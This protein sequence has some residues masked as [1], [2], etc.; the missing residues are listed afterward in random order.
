MVAPL[1]AAALIGG[2]ATI[3][4]GAMSNRSARKQA[5]QQASL[6]RE[7]AQNSIQWKTA[8]AKAAGVHPLY[9]LGTAST[10]YSPITYADSMGPALASAGQSVARGYAAHQSQKNTDRQY[11]KSVSDSN[12]MRKMAQD[13]M[14][15]QQQQLKAEINRTN[16]DTALR[17]MEISAHARAN[18]FANSQQDLAPTTAETGDALIVPQKIPAAA[19]GS[20]HQAAGPDRPG[21]MDV[22]LSNVSWLPKGLQT[23][24]VPW[25]EESWAEEFMEKLPVIA[26]A[27]AL[28]YYKWASSDDIAA[29]YMT[30]YGRA[31]M[32]GMAAQHF[33]KETKSILKALKAQY[34][35]IFPAKRDTRLTPAPIAP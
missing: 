31:R 4:G 5:A 15:L 28:R 21:W 26:A 3:I 19:K 20:P 33:G 10:P 12:F 8:D 16:T 35:K 11:N 30:P 7:F 27:N 17:Q 6:Q 13:N 22:R 29:M 32:I 25:T 18:Q 2:G 24:K 14:I 23:L 1:V 34:P 9:A